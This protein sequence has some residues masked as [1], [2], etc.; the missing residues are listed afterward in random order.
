MAGQFQRMLNKI[1]ATINGRVDNNTFDVSYDHASCS[2]GQPVLV[3]S[4]SDR[5]LHPELASLAFGPGDVGEVQISLDHE[6]RAA[7]VAAGFQC[8]NG[9]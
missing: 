6:H 4:A 8:W 1:F 2:Y 5:K 7:L 9:K 3:L